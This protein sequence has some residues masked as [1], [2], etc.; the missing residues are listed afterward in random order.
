MKRLLCFTSLLVVA[1]FISVSAQSTTDTVYIPGAQSLQISDIINADTAVTEHRVYVLD[2]GAIYYID[3]AFELNHPCKFIATGS[4][5]RPPVLAPAIRADGTSEEW[6]FKLIQSGI[7]VELN[8]LYLLSMR[9]DGT[10]LGWSRAIHIGASNCSLKLRRIVFDG[11]TEAGIRVDGADFT[12]LDVQDCHF[13]NFIHSSAYFGGQPFMVNALDHP[14]TTVFINNTFFACNSYLIS[15]RGLGPYNKFEHNSIV[16]GAVNPMLIR[17]AQNFYLNNNIFYAM[18]AWGGDPE[19]VNQGWFLNYP[20]TVSSS[21]YR[22][23]K[24]MTYNGFETTGPEAYNDSALGLIFNYSD[25]VNVVHNNVYH[26]PASLVQFYETWN[27]TVT[28]SDSVDMAS[29]ARLYL[30]RTLT[31]A[32][33]INDLGLA[34]LDSVGDPNN[35][36]Y[37]PGVS[38]ANNLD[39]DPGFTDAAVVGHIDSLIAYVRRIATRTLDNPWHF[40]LNFPPVWPV[41]ENLAYSNATLMHGGTDG[42]AIGD[43]NWFPDQKAEWVLGVEQVSSEIPSAFSLSNAYPNPFNPETKVNFNVPQVS[44]V[45]LVVYNLLGQRV[46]T[47]VDE[48]IQA[49]SYSASWNGTDDYGRQMS[50]GIYFF[51]LES[52]SFKA[53]KKMILMK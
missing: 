20:D 53:T 11:W 35:P 43:L 49:G 9:S 28:V 2:R 23:R 15:V 42:F 12:K 50:S 1:L 17:Q 41:P 19:Q 37:A 36:D 33:W 31:L 46:R 44:K 22:I 8:D 47:L 34:V 5:A 26:M 40:E 6:F 32:R 38:V 52:Q 25:W 10:T 30:L 24:R 3:R 7:N 13:R 16:Y 51:S 45:K 29:G 4:A 18:H 21:V 48:E 14:D 27:D 39:V